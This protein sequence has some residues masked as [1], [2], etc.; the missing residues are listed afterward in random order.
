MQ[1]IE[2]GTFII[3]CRLENRG[4]CIEVHK[5]DKSERAQ[6]YFIASS[7]SKTLEAAMQSAKADTRVLKCQ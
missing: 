5:I 7:R 4:P 2:T 6:E 3:L 1:F